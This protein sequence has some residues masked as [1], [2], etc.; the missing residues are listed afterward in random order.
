MLSLDSWGYT[1][2]VITRGGMLLDGVE[3]S[4]SRILT[5]FYDSVWVKKFCFFAFL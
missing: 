4:M 1:S 3:K 2:R 5:V